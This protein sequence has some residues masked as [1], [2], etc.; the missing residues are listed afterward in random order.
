MQQLPVKAHRG[1]KP[2]QALIGN[3][4]RYGLHAFPLVAEFGTDHIKEGYTPH[5]RIDF[6]GKSWG[7]DAQTR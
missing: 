1:S 5:F 6:L 3:L 4:N 7:D 2:S